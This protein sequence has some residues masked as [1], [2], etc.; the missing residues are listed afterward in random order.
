MC[1][2]MLSLL[3]EC[4][5]LY[6]GNI[7]QLCSS[8]LLVCDLLCSCQVLEMEYCWPGRMN[9]S[10]V[11]NMRRIEGQVLEDWVKIRP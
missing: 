5:L 2:E 6:G 9:F 11:E 4:E 8:K 1:L 10:S 7:L 3:I